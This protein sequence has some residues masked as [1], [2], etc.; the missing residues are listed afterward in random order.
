MANVTKSYHK[1]KLTLTYLLTAVF[2][3]IVTDITFDFLEGLP[4]KAMAF[5][6]IL[7]G[8]I[9]V[10]VLIT[11]NYVW[12]KFTS[13]IETKESVEQDLEETKKLA[14]LW[15]EKSKHFIRE[16]QAHVTTQFN[17]WNLS[18]SEKDISILILQ[19]MSSKEISGVRFTSERTIRN[20]CR[21]IY[22][23]SKLSGKSELSAFFLSELIEGYLE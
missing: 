13:E 9:L 18:K 12:K 10:L 2:L 14:L 3:L 21:S 4:M 8:S 22:E 5:D 19:G 15:E 20:Q 17:A 1:E 6:L 7:E 23:K 16:F 11:A